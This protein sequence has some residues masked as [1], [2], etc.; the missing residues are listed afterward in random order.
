MTGIGFLGAG[1]ILKEGSTVRGL[2]TSASIW[3]TAALGI[4]VGIG[5]Y[6]PAAAGTVATMLVLSAFRMIE[7]RL[8]SA[9]YAN[10]TITFARDAVM[11][12]A[13]VRMLVGQHGFSVDSL[14]HRLGGEGSAFEYRMVI[15]AR[16]RGG[17]ERSFAAP[18][19]ASRGQGIP[20]CASGRLR[21]AS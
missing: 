6:V 15:H 20:H 18:A 13:E 14:A 8:P 19:A 4:L 21:I 2:T 1:V 7:A 12:E 9:I 3:V 17:L 16:D 5:F 11:P 10:H